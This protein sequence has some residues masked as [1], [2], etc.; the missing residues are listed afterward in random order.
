MGNRALKIEIRTYLQ[1]NDFKHGLAGLLRLP[2][3]RAVNALFPLLYQHDSRLK[4]RAISAMGTL[5]ARLA[6]QDIETARIVMRR[7]MWNLNDESGGIGWGSAE[8]M[9]DIMAKSRQMA[10]E[11]AGILIAYI[12]PE[13]N[14]IELPA[15]QQ[16]VLWGIGRLAEAWP[17]LMRESVHLLIPYL[18]SK[19]PALRGLAAWVASFLKN[20]ALQPWLRRLA[21]D[22]APIRIYVED[23]WLEHT[24]GRLTG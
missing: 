17:E 11:Y 1:T 15:L 22:P 7:L 21:D 9:G 14:Y 13:G 23:H 5:V 12:D 19:D 18:E 6:A 10:E 16:G 20:K 4:W 2:T 3:R 24:I 8:A